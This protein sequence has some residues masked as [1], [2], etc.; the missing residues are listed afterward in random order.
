MCGLKKFKMGKGEHSPEHP[1]K[2]YRRLKGHA[3]EQHFGRI[4]PKTG[5]YTGPKGGLLPDVT[6]KG[7]WRPD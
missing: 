5:V 1:V 6:G 2:A 3:G 4:D 7:R